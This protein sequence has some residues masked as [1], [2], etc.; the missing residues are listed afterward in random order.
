MGDQVLIQVAEFLAQHVREQDM[1]GRFGGEEFI[2]W[3]MEVT[4]CGTFICPNNYQLH[5]TNNIYQISYCNYCIYYQMF[6]NLYI[7]D[8]K[9]EFL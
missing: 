4:Q 1:I 7:Q 9:E 2:I 5:L 6:Y 3:K 8:I